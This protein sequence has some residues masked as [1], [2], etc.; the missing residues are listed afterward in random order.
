[1][2]GRYLL[3]TNVI[4]AL[5]AQDPSLPLQLEQAEEVFVP[6]IALGELYYGARKSGRVEQNLA[7]IDEFAASSS[8]LSCSEDTAQ[9]YGVIKSELR[10]R[11]RPIPENDVWIAAIA[12]QYSLVLAT[13]D[14][15][16]DTIED[17]EH[18]VW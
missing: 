2:S 15:H 18:E 11:G 8:V 4:I 3:D 6:S 13:R 9:E 5:F 14:T 17:L 16:F 1:M 10:A 7:R 12:R